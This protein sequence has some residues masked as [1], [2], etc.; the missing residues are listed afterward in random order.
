[1]T[2]FR[3]PL[4]G[5]LTSPFAWTWPVWDTS[6]RLAS[7]CSRISRCWQSQS[8]RVQTLKQV[9]SFRPRSADRGHIEHIPH[10]LLFSLIRACS[11]RDVCA[12]S[13]LAVVAS[14]PGLRWDGYHV[15]FPRS[16]SQHHNLLL[17]TCISHLIITNSIHMRPVLLSLTGLVHLTL[18][19]VFNSLS[20]PHSLLI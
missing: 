3:A 9:P 16:M 12:P 18:A 8:P 5:R 7:K 10:R 2:L 17:I 13:R 11:P 6:L 20:I 14:Y 15:F 19:S 4:A 1:M